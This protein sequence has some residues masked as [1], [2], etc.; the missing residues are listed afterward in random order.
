MVLIAA[1]VIVCVLVFGGEKNPSPSSSA[2]SDTPSSTSSVPAAPTV[3]VGR[4]LPP[5]GSSGSKAG[6]ALAAATRSPGVSLASRS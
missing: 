4:R 3:T 6:R 1:I 5:V 2:P